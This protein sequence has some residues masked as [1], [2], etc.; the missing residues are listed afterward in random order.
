MAEG[1]SFVGL[2]AEWKQNAGTGDHPFKN[3]L[4]SRE[5]DQRRPPAKHHR[6]MY[7]EASRDLVGLVLDL[8]AVDDAVERPNEADRH[9]G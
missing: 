7:A 1:T 4:I 3:F 9:R 6:E 2:L 8:Q 5:P